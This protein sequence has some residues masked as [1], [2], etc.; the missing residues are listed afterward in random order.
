LG[1]ADSARNGSFLL[2]QIN[3]SIEAINQSDIG[4]HITDHFTLA[5]SVAADGGVDHDHFNQLHRYFE[6]LQGGSGHISNHYWQADNTTRWHIRQLNLLCH[7]FE[8]WQLSW[9]KLHTAPEWCQTQS[10]HVLVKCSTF[11]A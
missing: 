8:A 11:Y 1:F 2:E 4:Y 9:R 6:D 7:E 10:A 3:S 5:N